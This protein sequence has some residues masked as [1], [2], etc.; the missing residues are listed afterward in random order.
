MIAFFMR[1]S[2]LPREDDNAAS[3]IASNEFMSF[4]ERVI[5]EARPQQASLG[6]A[7]V[8]SVLLYPGERLPLLLPPGRYRIDGYLKSG[9]VPGD[10]VVVDVK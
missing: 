6:V 9:R 3:Y 1:R 4:S 5:V 7:P 2:S 8:D 10:P